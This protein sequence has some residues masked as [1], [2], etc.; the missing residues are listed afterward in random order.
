MKWFDNLHDH[1]NY[2]KLME[3][4]KTVWGKYE[5]R[6]LN[7]AL[8]PAWIHA[9]YELVK[10]FIDN[11]LEEGNLSIVLE[12]LHSHSLP[13]GSGVLAFPNQPKGPQRIIHDGWKA[14]TPSWIFMG[15][16]LAPENVKYLGERWVAVQ[17]SLPPEMYKLIDPSAAPP[18]LWMAYHLDNQMGLTALTSNVIGPAIYFEDLIETI[19]AEIGKKLP[20]N[21]LW[22]SQNENN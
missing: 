11:K 15:R 5:S 22:E 20:E 13:D 8:E 18:T 9:G 2:D 3:Q 1:P 7:S 4:A 12:I 14:G 17:R 21:P 10:D 16:N 6:K 19:E